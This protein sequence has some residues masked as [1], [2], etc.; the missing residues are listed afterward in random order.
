MN[1]VKVLIAAVCFLATTSVRA[2][3]W[4]HAQ[5]GISLEV[6]ADLRLGRITDAR[7]DGTDVAIQLG[8]GQ[9]VATFFV[10]R[11]AYPN[12][13]MWYERARRALSRGFGIS[14]AATPQ[15]FT[16]PGTAGANGL[17]EDL[18]V[19]QVRSQQFPG[20][21][22]T[23]VAV[24]GQ[25]EW[26]IK[27]RITSATLDRAQITRMMDSI[28]A[29][30][31]SSSIAATQPLTLPDACPAELSFNGRAMTGSPAAAG[32]LQAL[33]A[34]VRGRTGLAANPAEWCRLR[35]AL[36]DEIVSVF[37]KRDGGGWV[38][39]IGDFGA[40]ITG[41]GSDGAGSPALLYGSTSSGNQ[42]L[43]AYD[44]LPAPASEVERHAGTTLSIGRNGT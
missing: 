36:P 32:N 9:T 3:T 22:A 12:V 10:F 5:S 37:A 27:V 26:L 30:I 33:E 14:P 8:S 40:A 28:I 34:A 21:Q 4:R 24:A 13:A 19:S 20:A 18:D 42:L 7:N 41:M 15:S 29:G 23:A 44:S 6:P 17:R 2:E 39:L 43:S 35:T 25:G 16:L 11:P 31:R 1:L 38:A